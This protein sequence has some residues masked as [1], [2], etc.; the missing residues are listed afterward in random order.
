MSTASLSISADR[1]RRMRSDR[2][3]VEYGIWS[4]QMV[5]AWCNGSCTWVDVRSESPLVGC[6]STWNM[7]SPQ[8]HGIWHEGQST[9][10]ANRP[11]YW[12]FSNQLGVRRSYVLSA[13]QDGEASSGACRSS[14]WM[15]QA[16]ARGVHWPACPFHLTTATC[17]GTIRGAT[18]GCWGRDPQTLLRLGIPTGRFRYGAPCLLRS[19]VRS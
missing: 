3:T 18:L 14:V 6:G 2:E 9:I 11:Q 4:V 19:A 13:R 15:L 8:P 16:R 17:T 10:V 5:E 12:I 7:A 1:S